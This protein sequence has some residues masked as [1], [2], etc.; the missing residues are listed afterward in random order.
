MCMLSLSLSLSLDCE[1]HQEQRGLHQQ[2]PSPFR[3][4]RH[5]GP[6]PAD[7]RGG[8]SHGP[9]ADGLGRGQ[10]QSQS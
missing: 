9:G 6:P 3:D 5:H 4:F 2:V 7:G 8:S 10:Y 1:L